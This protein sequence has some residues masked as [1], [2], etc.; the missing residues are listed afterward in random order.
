MTVKAFVIMGTRCSVSMVLWG[1]YKTK[2]YT[3][4]LQAGDLIT[5]L[6]VIAISLMNP[7]I[8]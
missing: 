7:R 6:S 3:M 8:I 1:D 4:D 2:Y 5:P